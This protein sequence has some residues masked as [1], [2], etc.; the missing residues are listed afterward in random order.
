V[1]TQSEKINPGKIKS[2]RANSGVPAV[3][4]ITYRRE[5]G[6]VFEDLLQLSTAFPPQLGESV[7]GM[8]GN[9]HKVVR[10]N[11]TYPDLCDPIVEVVCALPPA[12]P[13]F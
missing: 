5:S 2:I 7:Q 6:K 8:D 13:S 4:I 1:T 3:S 9:F 10:V 11:R 12:E